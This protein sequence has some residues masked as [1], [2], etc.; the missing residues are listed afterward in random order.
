MLFFGTF[1]ITD[2]VLESVK[3][4]IVVPRASDFSFGLHSRHIHQAG[5]DISHD[6]D[7]IDK[8]IKAHGDRTGCVG[9]LMADRDV[10]VEKVGEY[11]QTKYNCS[12]VAARNHT[13]LKGPAEEHGQYAGAGYIQDIA[14]VGQAMSGFVGRGRSSSALV[15]EYMDYKRRMR[16]WELD[17]TRE[18]ESMGYCTMGGYGV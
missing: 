11:I 4:D 10:T 6:T 9:Y 13:Q 17:G 3:D 15:G 5:D 16:M 1:S 18:S 7:C 8:L 12:V 14:V 2:E